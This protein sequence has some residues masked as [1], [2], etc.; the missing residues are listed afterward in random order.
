MGA[1]KCVLLV[2][3]GNGLTRQCIIVEV[4]EEG[5][6]IFPSLLGR[7]SSVAHNSFELVPAASSFEHVALLE[8]NVHN[9]EHDHDHP[10]RRRQ[11]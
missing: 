8:I 2:V 7:A 5:S 9:R 4:S 6:E 3:V 11:E 10:L 1:R